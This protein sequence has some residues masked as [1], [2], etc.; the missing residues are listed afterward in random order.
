M[1][2]NLLLTLLLAWVALSCQHKDLGEDLCGGN[3]GDKSIKVVINW[4]EP[5]TQARTMRINLFSQTPGVGDYGRDNVTTS[6]EKYINLDEGVDYRP[7]CYDYN[8][9]NIYFRNETEMDAFEA[10]FSGAT[11]ATYNKYA[12]PVINE[13]TVNSPVGSEFYVHAWEENFS[14][15]FTNNEKELV[16]NFYPKNILRQ[17]TY[18][19]NKIIGSEYVKDA[20]GAASGMAAVYIFHTNNS[21]DTRSTMLFSNVKVGYDEKK[22]YGYLEGEFYTFAPRAPYEN[23][24]TMEV[25]SKSSAY[26]NASWNVS[27]QI[28]ESMTDRPAKLARDGYDILIEND[29]NSDESGGGIPEIDPGNPGEGGSGSGF[30]IGVGEWGD[31]VIVEL[32]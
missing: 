1:K 23:W 22:G 27:G 2:R 4:D 11:R 19:V 31:E 30:E 16:L 5:N 12:A 14:T 26:Y 24:F 6:G 20:R 7:F 17:F 21:T 3:V 13:K 25:Y 18:R 15:Y 9:S 29:P 28:Q 10:Y 32:K 8:A